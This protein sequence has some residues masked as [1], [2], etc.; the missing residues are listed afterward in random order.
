MNDEEEHELLSL[1]LREARRKFEIWYFQN[2][3]EKYKRISAMA[4]AAGLERSSIYYKLIGLGLVDK[5][6]KLT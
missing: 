2:L 6:T 3:R 5:K 1:P 4:D